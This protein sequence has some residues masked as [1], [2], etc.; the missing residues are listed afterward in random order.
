MGFVQFHSISNLT[1]SEIDFVFEK[2]YFIGSKPLIKTNK[3]NGL[4]VQNFNTKQ[5]LEKNIDKLTSY[6]F[7]NPY[8][9]KHSFKGSDY[10]N[11]EYFELDELSEM[12]IL[13]DKLQIVS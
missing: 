1:K 5:S 12:I 11:G 3:N 6:P 10:K 9:F 7:K 13:Y 4:Y 2:E 8:R